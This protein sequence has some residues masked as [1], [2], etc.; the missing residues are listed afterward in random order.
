[1]F[2]CSV[3][4]ASGRKTEKGVIARRVFALKGSLVSCDTCAH[5]NCTLGDACEVHT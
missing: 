2:V 5:E 1:M 3:P 4:R